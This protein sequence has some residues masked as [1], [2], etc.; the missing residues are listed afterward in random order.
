MTLNGST[1]LYCTNDAS[2]RAHHA[3]FKDRLTLS[4]A[5]V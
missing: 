1:A 2:F 5:K 3:N 4:E